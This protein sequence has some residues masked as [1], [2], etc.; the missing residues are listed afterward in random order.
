MAA[1]DTGLID[2]SIESG[3]EIID[4]GLDELDDDIERLDEFQ[5]ELESF[6]PK[7]TQNQQN[8][9]QARKIKSDTEKV[10]E[11]YSDIVFS[12]HNVSDGVKLYSERHGISYE[13][14]DFLKPLMA[15]GNLPDDF[16]VQ[17]I[18]YLDGRN[19][20][21]DDLVDTYRDFAEYAKGVGRAVEEDFD[22]EIDSLQNYRHKIKDM[23]EEIIELDE[24]YLTPMN[25]DDAI[26]VERRLSGI[27]DEIDHLENIRE[28][29][30]RRRDKDIVDEYF[31][32]NL[33][34]FYRDEEVEKP[35]LEDL[36]QLRTVV[37]QAYDRL[38]VA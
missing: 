37:N 14:A 3:L 20:L 36:E 19:P 1:M 25:I 26:H 12:D 11:I 22:V 31:E 10:M 27:K 9:I 16:I 8:M 29:E 13:A 28:H 23:E 18:K 5:D 15:V 24:E 34:F 35:V 21:D 7:M 32:R 33:E 17:R 4:E 30:L 2:S 38:D 6:E